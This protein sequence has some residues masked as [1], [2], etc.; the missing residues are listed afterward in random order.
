MTRIEVAANYYG[1][2]ANYANVGVV[3]VIRCYFYSGLPG[4]INRA[5]NPPRM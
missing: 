2:Y 4:S 1:N 3:S 5:I